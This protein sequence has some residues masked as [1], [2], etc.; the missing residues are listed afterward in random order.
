MTAGPGPAAARCSASTSCPRRSGRPAPAACQRPAPRRLR[1][2][3]G[4]G[5]LGDACC[6][7]TATSAS[8]ATRS[9]CSSASRELLAPGGRVVVEL[10]R[11]GTGV[12]TRHVRLETGAA[13]S[14]P[15]AWTL[16]GTDAI[17]AVAA[18]AGLEVVSCTPLRCR[19]ARSSWWWPVM[20]AAAV[21]HEDDFSSWLRSPAVTARVGLWL[22]DQLRPRLRDRGDQPLR[23]GPG[24]V[25]AVPDQPELGLPGDPGHPRDRRAPPPCRCSWSSSGPS[26]PSSS[27][28]HRARWAT[29]SLHG[30]ERVSIAV[31]V[32]A[33]V[34]QLAT[35]IANTAQWYPW[36][37]HFRATHYAVAWIAI[38]ALL[39]AHRGQAADDPQRPDLRR[40]QHRPGPTRRWRPGRASCPGA[41][42]SDDVGRRRR[43]GARDRRGDRAGAAPGVGA[44]RPVRRR[45]GRGPDQPHGHGARGRGGRDR[46]SYR[47][48][49][50]TT[51]A[52]RRSPWPTSGDGADHGVA[53][54]RLCR[55]LERRCHLDRGAGCATCSPGRRLDPRQVVVALAAERGGVRR[56]APR[57]G[58]FTDDPH[59]L[60]ALRLHGEPLSHRPRLPVPAD[61]AR[62]SGGAADQVGRPA[63][64]GVVRRGR[65]ALLVLGRRRGG[66]T[67]WPAAGP[68]LGEHPCDG[69]LAGRRRPAPRRGLRAAGAPRLRRGGA[70]RARSHVSLPGSWLSWSWCRSRC[71]GVPELGRFGADPR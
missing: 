42:S 53:A 63:G 23:P 54:H 16:V 30:L 46:A 8:A 19:F 37:F 67:G 18:A 45:A 47:W 68:R 36:H 57:A 21:P 17:C 7:P 28:A 34:F 12:R 22:G 20:R 69:G 10:A 55:G 14:E 58:N 44:R 40:R 56:S 31:L 48:S 11:P 35:G 64:G 62:P 26:S 29:C 32:A 59:T 61:R 1:P 52:R 39:R 51:A 50:R 4:R 15:F 43:R 5:P 27:P 9:P 25:A 13:G 6:S 70:A 66:C 33:A 71:V 24:A 38:G 65:V 2:A 3:P 60:L 49:S 41:G